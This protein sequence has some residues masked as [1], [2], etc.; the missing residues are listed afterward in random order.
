MDEAGNAR[1]AMKMCIAAAKVAAILPNDFGK[2]CEGL[3]A[4]VEA[5]GEVITGRRTRQTAIGR[6]MYGL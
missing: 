5:G 1:K 4:A 6:L 2:I 3:W